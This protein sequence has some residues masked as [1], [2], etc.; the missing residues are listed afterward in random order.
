MKLPRL[1]P[2]WTPCVLLSP[3]VV[4][5]LVFGLFPLAFSL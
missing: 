5:F 4:L 2:A 3:F 1:S